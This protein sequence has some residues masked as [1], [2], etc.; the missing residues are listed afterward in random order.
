MKPMIASKQAGTSLVSVVMTL[1]LLMTLA[2]GTSSMM[3][4]T[5]KSQSGV[6]LKDDVQALKRAISSGLH[7]GETLR[8]VDV[9]RDCR[10]TSDLGDVRPPYLELKRVLKSGAAQSLFGSYDRKTGIH[11]LGSLAIQATCSAEEGT[12]IV[13]MAKMAKSKPKEFA[14]HPITGEPMGFSSSTSLLFGTGEGAA[15][16][17]PTEFGSGKTSITAEADN[18]SNKRIPLASDGH[19]G[20]YNAK[21]PYELETSDPL[22]EFDKD[23]FTALYPGQYLVTVAFSLYPDLAGWEDGAY[24]KGLIM[25]TRNGV[26]TPIVNNDQLMSPANGNHG[27][28]FHLSTMAT[29]RAGDKLSSVLRVRGAKSQPSFHFLPS[30]RNVTITKV[31]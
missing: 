13:R 30:Q 19:A 6:K 7:C 21:V 8:D 5:M 17:C 24:C 20:S 25:R 14:K 26:E 4:N 28:H 3:A 11:R 1:G 12:L 10:S 18:N 2:M 27:C 16:L 23:T 22:A 15:L 31:E 9:E 29:L